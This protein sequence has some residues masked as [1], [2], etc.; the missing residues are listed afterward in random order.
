MGDDLN[1]IPMFFD[2]G[3]NVAVDNAIY[4]LKEKADIIAPACTLDGAAS[5]I[6]DIID[7]KILKK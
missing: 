1:D 2:K 3:V 4:E 5:V 6:R 7:E